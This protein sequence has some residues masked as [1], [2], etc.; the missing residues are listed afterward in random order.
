M[1]FFLF[2]CL[3]VC[4]FLVRFITMWF[5]YF[6]NPIIYVAEFRFILRCVHCCGSDMSGHTCQVSGQTGE[7][8]IYP[9]HVSSVLWL[10]Q[11]WVSIVLLVDKHWGDQTRKGQEK[12]TH[13][14]EFEVS[15]WSPDWRRVKLTASRNKAWR[16][17][18]ERQNIWGTHVLWAPRNVLQFLELHILQTPRNNTGQKRRLRFHYAHG[19]ESSKITKLITC[20]LVKPIHTG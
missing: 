14:V 11:E 19:Q 7:D 2:V 13:S 15:V 5:Q 1:Q 17:G 18:G 4:L 20:I 3:L 10:N 9:C 6:G 8:W 12:D 16:R